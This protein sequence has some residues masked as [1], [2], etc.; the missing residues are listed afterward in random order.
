MDL[1][2][3]LAFVL[4]SVALLLIPGPT[5]FLILGHAMRQ[6]R[7]GALAMVAGITLGDA[8]AMSASLAGLGALIAASATAFTMLKGLGAI[9][10]VYLGVQLWRSGGAAFQACGAIPARPGKRV[11]RDGLM[12]TMLNPKSIAFFVAFVPQFTDP[13]A[14][15]LPQF[16]L[17]VVTFVTLAGLNALAWA[18][19]ASQMRARLA[20]PR[21]IAGLTRLGGAALV[22]MGLMTATLRR[23]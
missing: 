13:Q 16:A 8:L 15:V 20:R 17:L 1:H 19:A 22:G 11:F 2:L 18:L 7:A 5:N 4:A 23:A 10:L 12:V 3:W 6:G 9:Y 21:V 14:A